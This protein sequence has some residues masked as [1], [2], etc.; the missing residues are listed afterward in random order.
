M[1]FAEKRRPLYE[2]AFF[3][4]G[5]EKGRL[6]FLQVEENTSKLGVC[7]LFGSGMLDAVLGNQLPLFSLARGSYKRPGRSQYPPC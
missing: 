6:P 1:E 5:R 3:Y 2:S 7:V 4:G